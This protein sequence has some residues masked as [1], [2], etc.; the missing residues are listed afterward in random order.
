MWLMDN[1]CLTAPMAAWRFAWLSMC[2][3]NRETEVTREMKREIF[4]LYC[5]P[6]G[7]TRELADSVTRCL[8][9]TGSQH[10]KG[11]RTD[12]ID[13]MHT[14]WKADLSMNLIF[15]LFHR[16]INMNKS[17]LSCCNTPQLVLNKGLSLE[18]S[19]IHLIY[20]NI[21]RAS[22]RAAT[23]SSALNHNGSITTDSE[24]NHFMIG[25]KRKLHQRISLLSWVTEWFSQTKFKMF[26]SKSLRTLLEVMFTYSDLIRKWKL[27][28]GWIF[29]HYQDSIR[30]V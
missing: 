19:R 17:G 25:C 22:D 15:W 2:R 16:N 24:E 1:P 23:S 21:C 18:G 28:H 30:S 5:V 4:G 20:G 29:S 14:H 27:V 10:T 9:D 8:A 13:W 26:L 6:H 7:Q 3:S 12:H 11:S